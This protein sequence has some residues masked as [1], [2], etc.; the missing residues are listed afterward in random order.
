MQLPVSEIIPELFPVHIAAYEVGILL[1]GDMLY[2]ALH[3][4]Y[5][6][7]YLIIKPE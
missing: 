1:S 6:R 2:P 4:H 7:L 5:L 3:G